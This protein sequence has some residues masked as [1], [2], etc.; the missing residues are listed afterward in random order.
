MELTACVEWLFEE[1]G[2]GLPERIRAASA[3]GF[4]A[5]EFWL[6]KDSDVLGPRD[7]EAIRA[8]AEESN[9]RIAGFLT[10]PFTDLNDARTH[11]GF[12]RGFQDSV[13][14]AVDLGCQT[15]Y[16]QGG[17]MVAGQSLEQQLEAVATVLSRAARIADAEGVTLL[18]EPVNVN[19]KP[20]EI[21]ATT[22]RGVAVV[23]AVGSPN[24]KLLYDRYHAMMAGEGLGEGLEGAYSLLGHVHVAELDRGVPGSTEVDWYAALRD[25]R[26]H[27]YDGTIGL[28]YMPRSVPTERSVEY[29]RDVVERVNREA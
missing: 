15:L 29:I 14:V 23:Q 21:I 1:R 26:D 5:V 16:T 25:F 13:R 19:D 7:V 18:L 20:E 11:D 12:L 8:A 17:Q 28:E 3:A 4:D 2:P 9:V 10:M 22:Q 27:G 6:W 24:V